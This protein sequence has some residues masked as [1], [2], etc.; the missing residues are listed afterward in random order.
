MFGDDVLFS[1]KAGAYPYTGDAALDWSRFYRFAIT[2]SARQ[3]RTAENWR[4]RSPDRVFLERKPRVTAA[5]RRVWQSSPP[6]PPMN[7]PTP[8]A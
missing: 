6:S 1:D 5:D 2:E 4:R 7:A 3:L 8:S